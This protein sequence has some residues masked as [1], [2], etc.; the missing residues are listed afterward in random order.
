MPVPWPVS[1]C[2]L[3]GNVSLSKQEEGGQIE[4]QESS[5]LY[6]DHSRTI[7]CPDTGVKVLPLLRQGTLQEMKVSFEQEE[8][9]AFFALMVVVTFQNSDTLCLGLE[10][11]SG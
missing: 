2:V 5:S 9:L 8:A 10:M 4:F 6:A 7:T 1:C 11:E 3:S